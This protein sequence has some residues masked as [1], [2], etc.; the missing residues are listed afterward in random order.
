MVGTEGWRLE[1]DTGYWKL[2]NM[3]LRIGDRC[4]RRVA[5]RII[6]IIEGQS[7]GE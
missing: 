7:F 1:L 2:E 6:Y 3:E 5:N 4:T